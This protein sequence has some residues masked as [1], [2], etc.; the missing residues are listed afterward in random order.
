[1]LKTSLMENLQ[2]SPCQIEDKTIFRIV[3]EEGT[4]IAKINGPKNVAICE[5]M[6]KAYNNRERAGILLKNRLIDILKRVDNSTIWGEA[7]QTHIARAG[8]LEE[9]IQT[10]K[11]QMTDSPRVMVRILGEEAVELLKVL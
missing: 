8:N 6:V 10:L 4:L 1:M 9:L 2:V 5:A 3:D 7:I 11:S